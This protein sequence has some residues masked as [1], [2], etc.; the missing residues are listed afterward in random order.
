ML[1]VDRD[2]MRLQKLRPLSSARAMRLLTH[3]QALGYATVAAFDSGNLPHVAKQLRGQFPDKPF[4]IA[5]DNDLH[6]ELTEGKN[7]GKEKALAAA[8]TVDGTAIF[9]IFAPGEQAYPANMEPVTPAKARADD[10]SAMQKK[11][12]AK[13]KSFT[14]F[15]DLATQSVLG[16]EGV[17]RQVLYIVNKLVADRQEQFEAKQQQDWGDKLER[18]QQQKQSPRRATKIG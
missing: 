16:R 7:P 4:V 12:I 9:P 14:D 10:L 11:A 5:G 6:L 2:L 13:M 18:Q 15:N 1:S 17:D 8:K 3:I